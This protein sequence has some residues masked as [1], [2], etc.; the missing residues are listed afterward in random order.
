MKMDRGLLIA[1]EGIDGAG[2]TTQAK[3]VAARLRSADLVVRD[4][5][6]PTTGPW[7]TLIRES[8]LAGR[9]GP[10]EELAAF[11]EDRRE[12]VRDVI[13]PC[14]ARGQVVIVDRYYY[15]TA[16]YQ[17]ARGMDPATIIETNEAFAPR[18]DLLVV[19]D[20]PPRVGLDRIHA[21]G[22]VADHF[23]REDA[24]AAS[25]VIFRAL[26]G[27][28]VLHVDGTE[29]AEAITGRIVDALWSGPM[30]RRMC[31]KGL[32]ACEPA[33]CGYRIEDTCDHVRVARGLA[34]PLR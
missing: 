14:I 3:A 22:D 25:A 6:E 31:R 20:V 5:K 19:L 4:A 13:A 9:M 29:A 21:R 32:A 15:S 28:H 16:A 34:L 10:D 23:E 17:G 1:I 8:K 26:S 7:G 27:D 18:P 11:I 30:F 33:F 12:H 24:L 2:K